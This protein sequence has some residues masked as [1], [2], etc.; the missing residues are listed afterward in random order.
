MFQIDIQLVRFGSK[1][2]NLR[3]IG[4]HQVEKETFDSNN[5]DICM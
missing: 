5:E 1:A 2:M 3:K 4:V